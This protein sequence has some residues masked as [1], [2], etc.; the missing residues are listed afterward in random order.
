MWSIPSGLTAWSSYASRREGIIWLGIT[1]FAPKIGP[2]D[3][4]IVLDVIIDS[5]FHNAHM[6]L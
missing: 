4:I 2:L 1:S 6:N 5:H 3:V